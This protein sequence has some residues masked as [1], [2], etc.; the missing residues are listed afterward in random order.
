VLAHAWQKYYLG[1]IITS[2]FGI[3]YSVID[4]LAALAQIRCPQVTS[5]ALRNSERMSPK[6]D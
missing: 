3:E 5:L 4:V 6:G 1:L 2:S